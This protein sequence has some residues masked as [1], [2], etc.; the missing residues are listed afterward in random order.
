MA[1]PKLRQICLQ[2]IK[3]PLQLRK[4]FVKLMRGVHFNALWVNIK[5]ALGG[6]QLVPFLHPSPSRK[7]DLQFAM[8]WSIFLQIWSFQSSRRLALITMLHAHLAICAGAVFGLHKFLLA[9][10]SLEPRTLKWLALLSCSH[11]T[12]TFIF[13]TYSL[14]ARFPPQLLLAVQLQQ[15]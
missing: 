4:H 9:L 12:R 5:I 15:L 8:G 7:C 6:F 14:Q 2:Q 3:Q 13:P 1:T 10:V 11:I